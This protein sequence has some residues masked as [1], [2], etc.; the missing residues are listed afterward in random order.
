M[1]DLTDGLPV[2]ETFDHY[3][4]FGDFDSRDF[5]LHL[6]RREA[7]TPRE[8][9]IVSSIPY[10]QGEIDLSF[11]A[12]YRIYNNRTV[13]YIF[14]RAAVEQEDVNKYQTNLENQLMKI[15]N[16]ALYD[17]FIEQYHYTGKCESVNCEDDYY[18]KRM[19]IEITFNLHPFKIDSFSEGHGLWDPFN[20]ELDVFQEVKFDLSKER[21]VVLLNPGVS[22]VRPGIEIDWGPTGAWDDDSVEVLMNGISYSFLDSVEQSNLTLKPGANTLTIVPYLREPS[23]EKTIQFLFYKELI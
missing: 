17:S 9:E 20:F 8:S 7:P 5:N 2:I 22:P 1:I 13:T 15:F 10:R 18:F 12:G 19:I 14:Y 16:T 11:K 23:K 21:Q 4:T 3:I 6:H